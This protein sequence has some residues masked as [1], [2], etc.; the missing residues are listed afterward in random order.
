MKK[1]N[2]IILISLLVTLV[3]LCAPGHD[4]FGAKKKVKEKKVKLDIKELPRALFTG[5]PKDQRSPRLE[6]PRKGPRK[7][8]YVPKGTKN[9][10]IKKPVTA[11]D[12]EPIIGEI[13]QVTDG[14]REATEGSYVEFGPGK[15][16]VQID[17][18]KKYSIYALLIWHYHSSPR[19]YRDVV[20][21][22][23]NDPDFIKSKTLFN[24]DHDNSSGFGIGKDYEY[25]ETFEGKLIPVKGKKARYVRLY[26]NGSTA[27][28][29]NHYIEVEVY[30]KK[31]K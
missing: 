28:E 24:N 16:Y 26:S 22:V 30:G 10:S 12:M 25:I 1:Q 21:R 29:M 27:S 18:K 8:L 15:Q 14:D 13:D 4:T 2:L 9:I 7:P 23:S 3:M 11:S 5:K 6:K 19:I 17:L 20:I 31:A